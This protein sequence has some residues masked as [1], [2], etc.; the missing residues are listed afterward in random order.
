MTAAQ[1]RALTH[2]FKALADDSRYQIFR[3]LLGGEVNVGSMAERV[4]LSEPT[5]SH[6]LTRLREVGLVTLRMDGNQRFYRINE[7]G[8]A[9]LKK[10]VEAIDMPDAQ[11]GPEA[12]DRWI[13]A[14]DWPEEDRRV[15]HE[16]TSGGHITTLPRKLKKL[17]VVLRWVAALFQP[18]T[19]YSE[20]DVNAII[21]QVY[22]A[23][24]VG[25]RRELVDMGYLRR[26]KGGGRYWVE[27]D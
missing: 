27:A 7:E 16:H 26:E 13:D 8:V 23:D 24:Y 5:V 1:E 10:L 4:G 12:D 19:T 21:R 9:R 20:Q 6:H 14:L 2:M 15:L 25:L 3:A 11:A 22:A 17:V 18:G